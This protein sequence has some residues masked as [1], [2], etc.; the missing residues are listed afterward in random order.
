MSPPRTP[1]LPAP[2]TLAHALRVA[3]ARPTVRLIRAT[4]GALFT[5]GTATERGYV[6]VVI[7]GV[8]VKVPRLAGATVAGPGKPAYVLASADFML[9]LGTVLT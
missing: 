2:G 1:Q 4:G 7:D 6:N 5:A 8:T 9:Y 3:L